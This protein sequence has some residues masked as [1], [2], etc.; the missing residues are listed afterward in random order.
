V[1]LRR[2]SRGNNIS[3]ASG[4]SG[5]ISYI[6]TI[7]SHARTL[8]GTG[9]GSAARGLFLDLDFLPVA[10]VGDAGDGVGTTEGGVA[11][12][13]GAIEGVLI[14]NG[15]AQS[16]A[17]TLAPYS[18][19]SGFVVYVSKSSEISEGTGSTSSEGDQW[20]GLASEESGEG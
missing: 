18:N 19:N 13:N 9:G 12:A 7:H 17:F 5:I 20:G 6:E 16:I 4:P 1:I 2:V 11:E 15:N 10:S 3:L 8:L 14:S